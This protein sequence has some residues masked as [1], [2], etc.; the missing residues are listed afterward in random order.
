MKTGAAIGIGVAVL[1]ALYAASAGAKRQGAVALPPQQVVE[2]R[3]AAMMMSAATL[4][5]LKAQTNAA[6]LKRAVFPA[7]GL[8]AWA[9]AIPGMFPPGTN[10]PPTEALP[11]LWTDRAGFDAAAKDFASATDAVV[12]AAAANDKAAYAA[13]LDRVDESCKSCHDKYRKMEERH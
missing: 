2:A 6:D 10:V 8:N 5:T 12:E 3:H 9:K 7:Q 13:A 11:A 1:A 4:G